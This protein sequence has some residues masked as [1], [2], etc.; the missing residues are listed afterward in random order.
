MFQKRVGLLAT[1][2]TRPLSVIH[3]KSLANINQ[4]YSPEKKIGKQLSK[5]SVD[6]KLSKQLTTKS[7][8]P[9][10]QPKGQVQKTK[11]LAHRDDLPKRERRSGEPKRKSP[12]LSDKVSKENKPSGR[13]SVE[14]IENTDPESVTRK[15]RRSSGRKASLPKPKI[16]EKVP[17]KKMRRSNTY[18]QVSGL[19]LVVPIIHGDT[20]KGLK[21]TSLLN[22]EDCNISG[23]KV[24]EDSVR[25]IENDCLEPSFLEPDSKLHARKSLKETAS[26]VLEPSFLVE[27]TD[28]SNDADSVFTKEETKTLLKSKAT[29]DILEPSFLEECKATFVSKSSAFKTV[30]SN[31]TFQDSLEV[32][33]ENQSLEEPSFLHNENVKPDKP[34]RSLRKRSG[35][36]EIEN[37]DNKVGMKLLRGAKRN[38]ARKII[39][40]EEFASEVCSKNEG[41]CE[42]LN[43]KH[44]PLD[45]SVGQSSLLEQLKS[46]KSFVH[47]KSVEIEK[48]GNE[49]FV[50]AEGKH[51]SDDLQ[52]R[53]T[54]VKCR[55]SPRFSM[56]AT[57][58][59]IRRGTFVTESDKLKLLETQKPSEASP[60]RTTFTVSKKSANSQKVMNGKLKDEA[61]TLNEEEEPDAGVGEEKKDNQEKLNDGE[62]K[63]VERLFSADS[64]EN[65][66]FEKQTNSPDKI[67]VE[68]KIDWARRATLTVT[69]SRPSD[70][71]LEHAQ[72][73]SAV[74]KK[75]ADESAMKHAEQTIPEDLVDTANLTEIHE[76]NS[77]QKSSQNSTFE[78]PLENSIL[79]AKDSSF[80]STPYHLLPTSP[81]LNNSRR[82]THVVEKP[83]V[84][85]LSKVDGKQLFV[86]QN[87]INLDDKKEQDNNDGKKSEKYKNN[88][89]M[90]NQNQNEVQIEEEKL[91]VPETVG[92]NEGPSSYLRR[93]K[94]SARR[95]VTSL[96]RKSVESLNGSL[97]FSDSDNVIKTSDGAKT[98]NNNVVEGK[99]TEEQQAESVEQLFFV[100]FGKKEEV[101]QPAKPQTKRPDPKQFLKKR[102]NPVTQEEDRITSTKRSKSE[103]AV[104]VTTKNQA[105][106][107]NNRIK[108]KQAGK[109][110]EAVAAPARVTRQ[111]VM[112]VGKLLHKF[113]HNHFS[114]GRKV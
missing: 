2:A 55:T 75:L 96:G 16:V 98:E 78:V 21:D 67:F 22:I 74:M 103:T 65:D 43:D 69:K 110:K 93:R 83:K 81:L 57:D 109:V 39:N 38:N 18:S 20:V 100:P 88:I 40:P 62:V 48:S 108:S 34:R 53:E 51:P 61:Y 84:V 114:T 113:H 102:S 111:R 54:F 24:L 92:Q 104:T 52:R 106:D 49:S 10:V 86:G 42:K 33:V 47:D 89:N 90:N 112:S 23:V 15:E 91:D 79:V 95:S 41:K 27:A 70:A 68:Q 80:P 107:D 99:V 105:V 14:D 94:L 25:K 45:E 30:K 13:R 82:S 87:D 77:P 60:R 72:R 101:N 4:Q 66:S 35:I 12:R 46:L 19:G 26:H 56:P 97:N 7:V 50:D 73:T 32:E 63:Q 85:N 11:A 29:A 58:V 71:L 37:N 31:D 59:N 8:K 6:Q 36:I 5:P 64:L 3:T 76:V 44:K 28:Q 1:K 9:W 17:R